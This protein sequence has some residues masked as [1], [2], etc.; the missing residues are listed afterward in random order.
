MVL[1]YHIVVHWAKSKVKPVPNIEPLGPKTLPKTSRLDAGNVIVIPKM[2]TL[3][4]HPSSKWLRVLF[5]RVFP[6]TLLHELLQEPI[7]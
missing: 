6:V 2:V 7:L 3:P 5:N 1:D 4:N